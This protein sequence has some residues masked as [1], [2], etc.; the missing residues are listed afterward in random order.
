ME[1][2]NITYQTIPISDLEKF[3]EEMN[4]P[5]NDVEVI[6]I[7]RE[8]GRALARNPYAKPDDMG[9][10]LASY[11]G[12]CVGYVALI[13]GLLSDGIREHRVHWLSTL[14]VSPFS[15]GLGVAMGLVGRILEQ[16][17]DFIMTGIV[18]G[19]ERIYEKLGAPE[20]KPLPYL[21]LTRLGNIADYTRTLGRKLRWGATSRFSKMLPG[22][23]G[24]SIRKRGLISPNRFI[25]KQQAFEVGGLWL[26]LVPS[27]DIDNSYKMRKEGPHFVRGP[28]AIHWMLK[29]SW[30]PL[31]ANPAFHFASNRHAFRHLCFQVNSTS[32]GFKLGFI[33]ISLSAYWNEVRLKVLDYDLELKD[34]GPTIALVATE[35][36]KQLSV[37]SIILPQQCLPAKESI[38]MDWEVNQEERRYFCR[39]VKDGGL[40]RV[41]STIN[42]DL[43]DGDQAFD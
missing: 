31:D 29:Y 3:S 21:H 10:L 2:S 15:R 40:E 43:N 30:I 13:P 19:V 39:F 28:E 22:L 11:K 4:H 41:F 6:P 26:T 35:L 18:P 33:V 32:G 14:F 24:E 5:S 38:Q 25:F 17:L 16:P 20:M 1:R 23:L 7:N 27:E 9:L 42:L 12:N 34:P 37:T 36:A 8:R